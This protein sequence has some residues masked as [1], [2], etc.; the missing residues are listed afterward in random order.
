MSKRFAV[1]PTKWLT[2][3]PFPVSLRDYTPVTVVP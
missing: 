1:I 2:Y 3:V